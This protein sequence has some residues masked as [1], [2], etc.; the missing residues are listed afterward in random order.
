MM[1]GIKGVGCTLF[2]LA[3]VSEHFV[4]SN[5]KGLVD[6]GVKPDPVS[7]IRTID[8]VLSGYI[9]GICT[10]FKS[11]DELTCLSKGFTWFKCP[12]DFPHADSKERNGMAHIPVCYTDRHY[13]EQGYGPP[14]SWYLI[15][16][17]IMFSA[18]VPSH[19]ITLQ[20]W[21]ALL[22]P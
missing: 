22:A 4:C 9:Q 19:Q 17:M 20:R 15:R 1:K 21:A 10:D 2:L 14:R 12:E 5:Q 8:K 11:E 6:I 3:L 13:A 18:I 16:A 7:G